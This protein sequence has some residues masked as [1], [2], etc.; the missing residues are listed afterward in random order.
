[1]ASVLDTQ[2]PVSQPHALSAAAG[3]S[4]ARAY[5]VYEVPAGLLGPLK[6]LVDHRRLA[7]F[8][9]L[10]ETLLHFYDRERLIESLERAEART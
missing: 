10:D 5:L 6:Q 8:L 3:G 7:V 2:E 1:M 4:L 9:D